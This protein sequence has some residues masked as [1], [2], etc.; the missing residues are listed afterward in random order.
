MDTIMD[1]KGIE[2]YTLGSSMELYFPFSKLLFN[3][4][5]PLKSISIADTS[6]LE[7]DDSNLDEYG[8]LTQIALD[9]QMDRLRA[10]ADYSIG[11]AEVIQVMKKYPTTKSIGKS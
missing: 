10:S 1:P 4:L 5:E 9:E 3:Q 6:R 2:C 8:N 11:D 7:E